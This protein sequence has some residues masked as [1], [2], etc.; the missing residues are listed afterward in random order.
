MCASPATWFFTTQGI[1]NE[2][3]FHF[4]CPIDFHEFNFEEPFEC[5]E[6]GFY[7]IGVCNQNYYACVAGELYPSLCPPGGVFD[8]QVAQ[9]V[10]ADSIG[11]SC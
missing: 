3:I 4:L 6:D 7:P 9:C 1:Y 2:S 8:P 5:T 11:C 10:G